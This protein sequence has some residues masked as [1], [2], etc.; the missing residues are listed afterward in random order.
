MTEHVTKQK[1][2]SWAILGREL[3]KRTFEPFGHFSFVA[4]F[5]L[6]V[7]AVGGTGIWL[8]AYS[9]FLLP[10]DPT[11]TPNSLSPL[12][13]AVITFFPALAGSAS[14]QLIWAENNQKSLR[15]FAVL[16]IFALTIVAVFIAP[17][18][19]VHHKTALWVG[20]FASIV[21]LWTWWIANAHQKDLLDPVLDPDVT[22]GKKN[23][24]AELAG[25]LDG[26]TT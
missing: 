21:A 20:G 26:F 13:T 16:V 23:P 6:A 10:P 1:N 8:E 12:R 15:A 17:S 18:V 5:L 7:C 22:L 3:Q 11:G 9:Y 2:G 4:Y 25:D 14:L 24:T 19:A